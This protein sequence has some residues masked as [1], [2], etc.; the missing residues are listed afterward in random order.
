M[1]QAP[2]IRPH[3]RQYFA[4]LIVG[5]DR[6]PQDLRREGR[7][8]PMQSPRKQLEK[9]IRPFPIFCTPNKRRAKRRRKR[10]AQIIFSATEA[11]KPGP[12]QSER[13]RIRTMLT[14][15]IDWIE[16]QVRP[17]RISTGRQQS[18]LNSTFIARRGWSIAFVLKKLSQMPNIRRNNLGILGGKN[19]FD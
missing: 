13:Y 1:Q 15:R 9:N 17:L 14:G 16:S 5:R 18:I 10:Q 11:N 6:Q 7:Q 3:C 12:A 8:G 4:L 2:Q 19:E